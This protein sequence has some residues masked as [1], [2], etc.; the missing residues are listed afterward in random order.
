MVAKN[1]VENECLIINCYYRLDGSRGSD[2]IERRKKYR[3]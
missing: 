2:M 1:V 3:I